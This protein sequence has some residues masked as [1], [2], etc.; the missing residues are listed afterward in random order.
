MRERNWDWKLEQYLEQYLERKRGIMGEEFGG[1]RIPKLGFGLMRLPKIDNVRENPLDVERLK[2]MVDCFLAAGYRYF[3]TA[4]VYNDGASEEAAREALVKRHPR[5]DFFLADKLPYWK[6]EKHEDLEELFSTSL[7]RAG[8]EYFDFYLAHSL[9]ASGYER[10]V[11]LGVWDFLKALK[12]SGRARHI[13]FSFHDT[14]D[15]L[16]RILTEQPEVEFVQLQI[17]YVDWDSPKVQSA[18][19]YEVARK[20]NKPVII[21][22]PVKGGGLADMGED[23]V[24]PLL[25]QRP[26]ASIASWAFRYLASLEGV[27]AILS[28]MGTEEQLEDNIKTFDAFAPLDEVEREKLEEVRATLAARGTTGCTACGYCRAGCPARINIPE[29]LRILDDYRVYSSKVLCQHQFNVAAGGASAPRD[30]VVCASCESICPQNLPIIKL[31]EEV[32][33]LFG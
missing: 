28:G 17:N 27:L 18:A 21:M 13:G 23:I 19:N 14:A 30:C 11:E 9:S 31:L 22:E 20:H 7:E 15:V 25:E 8:V 29:F 33:S 3:D 26:D 4:Y 1:E 16:D 2:G 12:K 5:E 6:A 24:R 10:C 32:D